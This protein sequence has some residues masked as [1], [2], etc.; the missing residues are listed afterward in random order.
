[1][2]YS[3]I[4]FQQMVGPGY[5]PRAAPA[6][7]RPVCANASIIRPQQTG[8][9]P[10]CPLLLC[11]C[12]MFP[13]SSLWLLLEKKLKGGQQKPPKDSLSGPRELLGE[14]LESGVSPAM[15]S[16][17]SFESPKEK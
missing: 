12:L 14:N 17:L 7:G 4:F 8:F 5:S 3:Y 15:C 1:M 6:P 2:F 16:R 9:L 13:R 10:A 11:G